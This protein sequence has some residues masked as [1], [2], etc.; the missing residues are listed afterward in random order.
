MSKPDETSHGVIGRISG[1]ILATAVFTS[2]LPAKACEVALALAVDISGSVDQRE[3][4]IQMQGL[5]NG[6]RDGVISEALVRA[7]AA[8]ALIQWTGSSRQILSVPWTRVRSFEDVEK[9]ASVIETVPREWRS[10]STAIGDALNFTAE[11]FSDVPDCKRL[12]IDVSGDGESNEGTEP[13]DVHSN[14]QRIGITVNALV[15]EKADEDLTSYFWENVITGQGAFVVT[16]NGFNEYPDR[17]R[18]KLRREITNQ[19]VRNEQTESETKLYAV[20]TD[21][22]TVW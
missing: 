1:A 10:F 15:I 14:L 18:T 9:L 21:E 13:R 2:A 19:V 22:E 17:M 3:Y 8:I 6:L 20:R 12:V 16:A 7:E 11:H 5:A 4:Q